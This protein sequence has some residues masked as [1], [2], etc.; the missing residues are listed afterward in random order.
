MMN[1]SSQRPAQIT[2]NDRAWFLTHPEAVIR[3]RPIRAHELESL[4][5]HGIRPPEFR[6]SW[7][8]SSAAPEQV[9][10]I[11]L[12]RLLQSNP[13]NKHPNET[14]RIRLVTI[15]ARSKQLQAR[16]QKELISAVCEELMF[17]V[18]PSIPSDPEQYDRDL[19]Q[20]VA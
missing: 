20:I 1:D 15:K 2:A 13:G 12:I 4:K 14:L 16:L 9:A 8:K 17:L 7:C 10:V 3:F 11:D 19:K 5:M 18:I 6:P